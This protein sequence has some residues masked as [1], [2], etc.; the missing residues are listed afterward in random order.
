ML[1]V[2]YKMKNNLNII[3][4]GPPAVGKG[5]Q[6]EKIVS[7]YKIPHISTGDMFRKEIEDKSPLGDKLNSFM[8]KG[9]L[10]PDDVTIQIVE[11]RLT[12][13]DC[14]KGFLLDGFPRTI[15]QAIALDKMLVKIG[16][17]I[18]SCILLTA[19]EDSLT[20]RITSRRVCPSC[21][22][23]YN[24]Y[25]KKPKVENVCDNCSSN[26][27]QRNDDTEEAFKVRLNAYKTQT[28]PIADYYE[29]K[30]LLSKVDALKGID[31]VFNSIRL[32]LGEEF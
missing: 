11:K 27:I 20:S 13:A 9:L 23:S 18:S 26:L 1:K 32:I 29:K 8:S 3:L 15:P 30:G 7:T 19:D 2:N 31:E 28:Y 4:M 5:T 14:N 12:Q 17:E 6:S 24:I 25:T 21:G 10:V 22:A 16:K